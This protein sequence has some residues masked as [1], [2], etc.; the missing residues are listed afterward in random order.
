MTPGRSR[1]G[2]P[3]RMSFI[4]G[5]SASHLEGDES[6]VDRV[7]ASGD[8]R[9]GVRTEKQGQ[10]RHLVRT[11]HAPYRLR[12]RQRLE[13]LRLAPGITLREEVVYERRMNA[14]RRNAVT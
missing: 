4:S 11:T 8:E 1:P 6:A 3:N 2:S 7:V 9:G 14:G 5:C 12:A 10:P 13:H